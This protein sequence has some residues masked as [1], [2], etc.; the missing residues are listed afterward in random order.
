M[1]ITLKK[2]HGYELTFK[3][4]NVH[5]VEDIEERTY[6]HGEHGKID[7]TIPPTRDIKTEEIDKFTSILEDMIYYRKAAYDSSNLIK[8]LFEKLPYEIAIE[9]L[10]KLTINN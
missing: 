10:P 8:S 2:N 3:A 5:V 4:D 7:C 6:T 9:L 1:E